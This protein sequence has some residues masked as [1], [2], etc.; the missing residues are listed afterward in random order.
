[1]NQVSNGF[2]LFKDIL[3]SSIKRLLYLFLII[4][5]LTSILIFK[6][7]S[8]KKYKASVLISGKPFEI[9]SNTV[10]AKNIST[11]VLGGNLI[12]KEGEYAN[13]ISFLASKNVHIIEIN[14][15]D[16]GNKDALAFELV[17]YFQD[18]LPTYDEA[19]EAKD[20]ILLEIIERTKYV[21]FLNHKIER[22]NISIKE[23]DQIIEEASERIE[24]INEKLIK[25]NHNNV[26]HIADVYFELN[27]LIMQRNKLI[28][29][30]YFFE[31][32]NESIE[33]SDF[34]LKE[35]KPR[36]VFMVITGFFIFVVLALV[37]ISIKVLFLQR[38]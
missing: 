22:L 32:L 26:I 3:K 20:I 4:A 10:I 17:F 19:S 2:L 28:E 6:E 8:K 18:Y 21:D 7:V 37:S 15:V 35:D 23:L 38:Q 29:G 16:I 30:L 11:D 9:V 25:G 1:M 5:G 33:I 27:E 13:R 12:K 34:V 36:I 24:V 14:S 31:I